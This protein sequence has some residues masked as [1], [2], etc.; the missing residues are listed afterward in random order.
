M[1]TISELASIPVFTARTGRS[2]RTVSTCSLTNSGSKDTDATTEVVF[3]AVTAVTA[4]V[5]K[6]PSAANVLRS[7]CRPAPPPESDPAMVRAIRGFFTR[8]ESIQPSIAGR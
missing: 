7:A 3:C 8:C 2:V 1:A 5:P 6:T 4:L